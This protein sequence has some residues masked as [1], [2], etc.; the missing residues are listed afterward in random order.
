M[1]KKM[2]LFLPILF[3]SIGSILIY[4]TRN[5]RND[6]HETAESSTTNEF[7]AFEQLQQ[8]IDKELNDLGEALIAFV[9]FEERNLA[10]ITTD[11]EFLSL[12]VEVTNVDKNEF[13]LSTVI[14]SPDNLVVGRTFGLAIDD[15]T[16]HYYYPLD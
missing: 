16:N 11:N 1:N 5:T 15:Q 3:I 9:H 8:T 4:Q 14:S 12:P 6:Y 13:R 10:T 2:F 7:S